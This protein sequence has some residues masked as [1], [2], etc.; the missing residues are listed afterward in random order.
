MR[1][2]RIRVERAGEAA[3]RDFSG[4]PI[5]I[6]RNP[7]A[8]LSLPY[9]VVSNWHAI[10]R[11]DE[12]EATFF[13]L[14]STNG[15]ELD[16]QPVGPGQEV[17]FDA[18]PVRVVLGGAIALTFWRVELGAVTSAEAAGTIVASA[19]A[20]M[21]APTPEV[22]A[23]LDRLRP[24]FEQLDAVRRHFDDALGREL[25]ALP[26]PVRDA[27]SEWAQRA[28]PAS[29]GVHR[30]FPDGGPG[31][32]GGGGIGA[33]ERL[34]PFGEAPAT[35]EAARDLVRRVGDMMTVCAKG[36]VELQE[37][38]ESISREFGVK[39]VKHYTGL[40]FALS[41][42]EALAYLFSDADPEGH[43]RRV[44]EL[45]AAFSDTMSHQIATINGVVAGARA[46]LDELEPGSI[47]RGADPG[48]LTRFRDC[49]KT[50]VTRW[51]K[52]ANQDSPL[53]AVLFGPEFARVYAE[54]GGELSNAWR[55]SVDGSDQT[56]PQAHPPQ[57]AQ[58]QPHAQPEAPGQASGAPGQL[59]VTR[60]QTQPQPQLP[61][62][63][64]E[65]IERDV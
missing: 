33:G 17:G 19:Q 57:M 64:P 22:T 62:Q 4:S 5:Q 46:L 34:L 24:A 42:E 14:G 54:V 48:R 58:L 59:P 20:P 26:A 53:L 21:H 41:A 16:G 23:M 6:G 11:F 44:G 38:Q 56:Q 29:P 35:A 55:R 30:H 13:D 2:V 12:Q 43:R 18:Q 47:E 9:K 65:G 15:T 63:G 3:E 10:I 49:W 28:F 40:R 1:P 25:A 50:F 8:D 31:G 51:E 61:P 32:G 60:D 36:L 27:A 7:K 45:S 39:A 37:G 52:L